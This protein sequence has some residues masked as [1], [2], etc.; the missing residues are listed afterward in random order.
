MIPLPS[1]DEVN[2]ENVVEKLQQT[3]HALQAI[4]DSSGTSDMVL[5]FE[6]RALR[7][8]MNH[9]FDRLEN[10]LDNLENR[11]DS[12]EKTLD[13]RLSE[14]TEILKMIAKNTKPSPDIPE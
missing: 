6:I 13:T 9:G 2:A 5:A 14:Q 12:L 4:S 10:R 7:D 11:F 8:D 3:L 1:A